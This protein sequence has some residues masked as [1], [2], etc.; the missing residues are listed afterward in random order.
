MHNNVYI[1]HSEEVRQFLLSKITMLCHHT[2]QSKYQINKKST[3]VQA[4]LLI[5]NVSMKVIRQK[6]DIGCVIYICKHE[7][8]KLR[9][10]VTYLA[11]S[12]I[13]IGQW[14]QHCLL[15]KNA[16]YLYTIA[17]KNLNTNFW[18]RLKLIVSFTKSTF[19]QLERS[20]ILKLKVDI[21]T[22]YT[23]LFIGT[24]TIVSYD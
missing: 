9:Y 11:Y 23:S 7:W 10:N 22:I 12:Y 20:K 19:V 21:R 2:W 17:T 18:S 6:R 13:F 24:T 8:Y 4:L 16:Q 5:K 3:F 14:M 1:T 15:S